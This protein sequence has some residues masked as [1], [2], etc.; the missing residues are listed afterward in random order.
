ME[1]T[2]GVPTTA[3]QNPTSAF[4][5]LAQPA[6]NGL[7]ASHVV[8]GGSGAVL[9]AAVVGL[10]NHFLHTHVSSVDS[11]VIGSVAL[12]TGVGLGHV[13]GQVGIFGA[14]GR[15]LHGKR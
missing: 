13:I 6:P 12:S 15:L 4:V 14:F 3:T 5:Q 9:G 10:V 11:A 1:I 7:A 8:G 2:P